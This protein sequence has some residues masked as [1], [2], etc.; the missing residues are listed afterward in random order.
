MWLKWGLELGF[1]G[2][3]VRVVVEVGFGV[4]AWLEL[5]LGRIRSVG[6]DLG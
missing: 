5:G 4:R 2:V 1:G 3:G 6:I